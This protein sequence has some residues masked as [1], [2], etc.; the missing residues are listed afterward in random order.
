V[1]AL[2]KDLIVAQ[3]YAANLSAGVAAHGDSLRADQKVIRAP[4]PLL[5]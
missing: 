5:P 4:E 3:E 1:F 2:K